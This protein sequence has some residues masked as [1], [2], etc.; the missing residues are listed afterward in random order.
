MEHPLPNSVELLSP[1]APALQ[2]IAH[3]PRPSGV[4]YHSVIGVTGRS[5]LLVERLF[6]GGYRQPSDGVVPYSSAHLDDVD[7]EVVVPANH[8]EVHQHP[9]SILEVR[10]ILIDHARQHDER[11]RPIRQVGATGKRD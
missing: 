11:T 7:S 4:R 9:L 5:A 10:R 6:G 2:L 8:Y 3:R 1:D